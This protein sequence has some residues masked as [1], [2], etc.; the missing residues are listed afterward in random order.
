MW[1][2]TLSVAIVVATAVFP[3]I[4]YVRFG[5]RAKRRDI[6]DGLGRQARVAYFEMFAPS[7]KV[8]PGTAFTRFEEIYDRW[9][10]RRHYLVPGLLLFLAVGVGA[11]LVIGSAFY[12]V[13]GIDFPI[14]SLPDTAVAAL[15]G[16]YMWVVNDFIA[17]SSRQDFSPAEVWWAV[18]RILIAIPMAYAFASMFA[19]VLAPFVAFALGAFPM[20]SLWEMLRRLLLKKTALE[21]SAAESQD[22]I[23][24]LQGIDKEIASRLAK[25]D[26]TN[27]AQIAY[28]DPVRLAMGSNL[29]FGFIADLMSQALAFLYLRDKLDV[30]RPMGLRGAVEIKHF[31]DELDNA[32]HPRAQG[33]AGAALP[34]VAAALGMPVELVQVVL[35]EIAFDPYTD[36]L[37]KVWDSLEAAEPAPTHASAAALPEAVPAE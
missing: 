15:A 37:D 35:R 28:C 20:Q 31:V 29:S 17:R 12:T 9:Y 23:I 1:L 16:A 32:A 33:R 26:V 25:L 11:V 36:F 27:V 30:L 19:D 4:N 14:F 5:W 3:L 24:K 2:G 21:A 18:L 6:M 10:G 7:V 8:P 13:A 22:E 34:H